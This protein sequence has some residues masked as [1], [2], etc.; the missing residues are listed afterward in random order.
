MED[1]E[2]VINLESFSNSSETSSES[3]FANDHVLLEEDTFACHRNGKTGKSQ[4][5]KRFTWTT[6]SRMKVQVITYGA[7]VT[8]LELPDRNGKP[9]DVV[10]GADNVAGYQ[11]PNFQDSG[12]I[13]GRIPKLLDE[14]EFCLLGK[15]Y[16]INTLDMPNLSTV[17]WNY[18]IDGSDVVF[19][20]ASPASKKGLPGN[21]LI[22]ARFRVTTTNQLHVTLNATTDQATPIDLSQRL[23]LNMAGHQKGHAYLYKQHIQLN[24]NYVFP[25]VL[26]SDVPEKKYQE[27]ADSP[28]DLRTGDELGFAIFKTDRDGMRHTFKLAPT[29]N[30]KGLNFVCRLIDPL[31]GRSMEMYS[32]QR[33]VRVDACSRYPNPE[34]KIAPYYFIPE[35]FGRTVLKEIIEGMVENMTDEP[36]MFEWEQC[37]LARRKSKRKVAESIVGKKGVDYCKHQ[38]I[39]FQ[40]QNHPH[41]VRHSKRYP[42]VLLHPGQVYEH[43]IVYKFGVHVGG[44]FKRPEVE[45]RDI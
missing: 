40:P 38:A 39:F 16:D 21:V 15:T 8:R 7:R 41:A 5:V 1:Q 29:Q 3:N 36:K 18:F 14:E 32:N 33:Y 4:K 28:Y 13:I 23:E 24:A 11:L 45:D 12:A 6:N 26:A 43:K 2:Y 42:S 34:E 31:E 37:E 44:I 22:T 35:P 25:N 30:D 10:L 17:N 20:Y 27:V 9:I 19:S